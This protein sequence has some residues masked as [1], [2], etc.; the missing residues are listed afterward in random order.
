MDFRHAI[1]AGAVGN[2]VTND[3]KLRDTIKHIPGHDIKVL[4]LEEVVDQIQST[5]KTSSLEK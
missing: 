2:I 5:E 4:S 1:C 3:K